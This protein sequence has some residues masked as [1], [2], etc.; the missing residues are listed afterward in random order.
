MNDERF[1]CY[2]SDSIENYVKILLNSLRNVN[3]ISYLSHRDA[4]V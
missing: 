3:L 4:E 1:V 2:C